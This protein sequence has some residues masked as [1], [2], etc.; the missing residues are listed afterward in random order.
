MIR[1][2]VYV[3]D[4][5]VKRWSQAIKMGEICIQSHT[6]VLYLEA[7]Q[8]WKEVLPMKNALQSLCKVIRNHAGDCHSGEPRIFIAN[9]LPK[10]SS[11]PVQV[12]V[13]QCNFTLQ[14]A[15]R[16]ICRGIGRVF[17]LSIYEHFVSSEG[18]RLKPTQNYF[19]E[20]GALS[21]LG[22]LI[23]RE[24]CLQETGVKGYWFSGNPNN[25]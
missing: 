12:P 17:E 4:W 25:K 14:Q 9:R 24:C 13:N 7:S 6:V 23:F 20:T 2:V 21:Q 5:P 8:A 3:N 22:C 16:S 15:I 19:L 18:R 10:I 11:S 1:S